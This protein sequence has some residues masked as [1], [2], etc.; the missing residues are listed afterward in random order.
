MVFS[1][2]G[3][4]LPAGAGWLFMQLARYDKAICDLRIRLN[5]CDCLLA[6]LRLY[7]SRI[8]FILVHI[9]F[10]LYFVF[11]HFAILTLSSPA[12]LYELTIL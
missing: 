8:W 4:Q 7:D 5:L 9:C 10:E 1:V 11:F 6:I 3:C 2:V 12:P